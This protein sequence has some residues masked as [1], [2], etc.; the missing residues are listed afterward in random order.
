MIATAVARL[1]LT[2]VVNGSVTPS[3][4]RLLSSGS[5]RVSQSI[6]RSWNAKEI[7]N[8]GTIAKSAITRR[9][10]N[11]PRCSTSV[12]SSPWPRRRGKRFRIISLEAR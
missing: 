10:R 9:V 4:T 6:S 5:G 1:T 12:A 2:A 8:A 7:A 3:V 11:S